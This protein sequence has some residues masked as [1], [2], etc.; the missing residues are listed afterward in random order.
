[1]N[2]KEKLHF[3]NDRQKEIILL[4]NTAGLLSWDQETYM[5]ENAVEFR[6]EQLSLISSLV[7]ERMTSDEFFKIVSELKEENLKGD[8]RVMIE[9][10]YHDILRARKLPSKFVEKKSKAISLSV[11]KWREA[12]RK[13]DFSLFEPYL[14]K[15][16]ELSREEAKYIGLPGSPYNSLLDAYEEGMTVDKVEFEFMKL[17]E[18][19]LKL[20]G[21]IKGSD[22]Y[23]KQNKKLLTGEFPKEK[24]ISL[25]LDAINR[26]GLRRD[27]FRLDLSEHPFTTRLGDGDVRITSA[28]R[29]SNPMFAFESG[30]HEAGHGLYEINL[31]KNH[32]FNFLCDSPSLGLHES[33]SRFWENMIGK[34]K[35]FWKFYFPSFSKEFMIEGSFDSWFREI[36]FVEPGKIR[37]EADEVH[38]C[39]HIILRFELEKGLIEG[40]IDVKDLP[41]LWNNKM[42]ELFGVAPKNDSEGVMQD[43]H[44]AWGNFG[45]FP[46]YALGS[47]YS[48]Q[49]YKCLKKEVPGLEKDIEKGDFSKIREWLAEKIHSKGR[50]LLAEDLIKEA[51]GE[52]LNVNIYLDYLNEKYGEIYEFN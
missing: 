29:E 20:L 23:K 14:R 26:I 18:G 24:Q 45:Y 8:E 19:L 28:V 41:K 21:K 50:T 16:V 2:T 44:W 7:H 17:K 37:T 46:T 32:I 9:R 1:M 51:C 5:P 34:S 27:F 43:I 47:I 25:L 38:Y 36:N 3:V 42:I 13:K 4:S 30:I 6:S 48:A 11:N 31:P 40:N 15:I 33:Q 12:K 52:G 10:L 35:P 39:L 49:I 22:V